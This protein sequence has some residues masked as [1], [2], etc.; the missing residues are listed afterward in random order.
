MT[1]PHPTATD[2]T[3]S[4]I[5]ASVW[6]KFTAPGAREIAPPPALDPDAA[7]LARLDAEGE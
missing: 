5:Y 1:T 6:E 7:L 3:R 4:E 2:R